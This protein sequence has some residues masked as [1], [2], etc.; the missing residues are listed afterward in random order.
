MNASSLAW[1]GAVL[2]SLVVVASV[3]PAGGH[4]VLLESVP[5][6]GETVEVVK[7]LELRFNNRIERVEM[8]ST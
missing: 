2:L 8:A 7:R 6:A 1:T 4:G 5:K 3:Q